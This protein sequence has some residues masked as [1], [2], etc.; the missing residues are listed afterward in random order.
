MTPSTLWG[1][2]AIVSWSVDCVLEWRANRKI[3][4]CHFTRLRNT[5]MPSISTSTMSPGFI[6]LVAPGVPV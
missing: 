6:G 1:S 4:R 2:K 3:E 5:P